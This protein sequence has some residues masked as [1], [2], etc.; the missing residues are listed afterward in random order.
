M[1]VLDVMK[2]RGWGL[3]GVSQSTKAALGLRAITL[4]TCPK[5]PT[6]PV[7]FHML[8]MFHNGF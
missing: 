4:G 2:E 6:M 8:L 3:R 7:N 1:V 5:I